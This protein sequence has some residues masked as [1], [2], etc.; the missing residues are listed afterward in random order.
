MSVDPYKHLK[1]EKVKVIGAGNFKSYE[2]LVKEVRNDG[3]AVVEI[4]AHLATSK[5]VEN[6][7]M[8]NLS[9]LR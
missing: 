4:Q 8:T 1:G 2:G 6:I 7:K 9:V 5:R 3:T